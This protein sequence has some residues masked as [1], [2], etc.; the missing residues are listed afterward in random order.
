M[1][2]AR[3]SVIKVR[4]VSALPGILQHESQPVETLRGQVG[5]WHNGGNVGPQGWESLGA[6][7]RRAAGAD[8]IVEVRAGRRGFPH[9]LVP[10]ITTAGPIN[11]PLATG[12][13]IGTLGERSAQE[14]EPCTR[15]ARG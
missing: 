9:R 14:M 12:S 6:S 4:A 1:P 10:I 11:Q 7:V 8:R 13:Q 2:Q 3:Y 5:D 15:R